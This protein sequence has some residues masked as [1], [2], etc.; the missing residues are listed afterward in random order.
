MEQNLKPTI[1]S[2]VSGGRLNDA[3]QTALS[4]NDLSLVIFTCQLVNTTQIFR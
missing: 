2:M 4:A 1:Q 3:F